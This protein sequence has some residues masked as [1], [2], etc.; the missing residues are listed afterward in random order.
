VTLGQ[1]L[2]DLSLVSHFEDFSK[3]VLDTKHI[4]FY[5]SFIFFGLFLTLRSVESLKYR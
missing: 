2:N 4:V 1:W 5:V 3:G